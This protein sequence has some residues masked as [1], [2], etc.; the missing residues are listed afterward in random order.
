MD[1]LAAAVLLIGIVI[2]AACGGADPSNECT[3]SSQCNGYCDGDTV[4]RVGC[5]QGECSTIG[6]EDC[7]NIAGPDGK[8]ALVEEYPT[9]IVPR[10]SA[11]R[12][13][14]SETD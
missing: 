4:V 1:R 2:L 3:D 6:S 11:I 13:P 12:I 14:Q 10:G 5:V 9:C 8:C 7:K